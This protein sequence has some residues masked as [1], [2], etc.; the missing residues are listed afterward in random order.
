MATPVQLGPTHF[1]LD[2]DAT[3]Q[4]L[5]DVLA[6]VFAAGQGLTMEPKIRLL[7]LQADGANG[8]PVYIGTTATMTST[9]CAFQIPAGNG[10]VPAAPILI[11]PCN[12]TQLFLSNLY[13][14]GTAG[15]KLRLLVI[16]WV[17]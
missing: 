17:R 14:L 12:S 10:G 5:S 2:L 1:V 4:R 15:Q 13:A 11:G 8:N 9:D 7:Y 16:P 3:V 6:A